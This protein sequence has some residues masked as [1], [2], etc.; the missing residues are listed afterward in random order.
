MRKNVIKKKQK[1]SQRTKDWYAYVIFSIIVKFTNIEMVILGIF[2]I[3]VFFTNEI[4]SKASY[5]NIC[6]ML[7]ICL[8]IAVKCE[9]DARS[10][11]TGF[12]KE[13]K[14]RKLRYT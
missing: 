5:S 9:I 11:E 10:I 8:Y 14:S 7:I 6:I 3:F 4:V 1:V 12:E 2:S 13:L